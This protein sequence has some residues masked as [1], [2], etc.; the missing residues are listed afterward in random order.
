MNRRDFY[1]TSGALGIG[2]L[3]GKSVLANE[4]NEVPEPGFYNEE[5]KKLPA[6]EFDVVVAGGVLQV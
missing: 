4:L 2:L 3:A 5:A 1:K 6:R